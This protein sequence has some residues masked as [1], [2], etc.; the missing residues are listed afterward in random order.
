MNILSVNNL[1]KIGRETPLFT[2]VTFGLDSGDKA[3]IIGKNGTGKSTL[4]NVIAGV[5]VPDEGIVVMNKDAGVSYLSQNPAFV[6][7]DTIRDHIFKSKSVK[8]ETIREYEDLCLLMAD[9]LTNAQQKMFD[10]R[11]ELNRKIREQARRESFIDLVT[12]KISN[13]ASLELNYQDKKIIE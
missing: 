11:T 10:E 4:L 13:V 7:E 1:S 2:G 5:L 3:A 6:P 9:G 8:L 12:D